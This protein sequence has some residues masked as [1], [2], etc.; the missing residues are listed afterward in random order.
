M[1]TA[2]R[3]QVIRSHRRRRGYSQTVLAGLVGRSESWL[4][5]VERGKLSVDSHEVLSRLAAVLRLPLEE[6]TGTAAEASPV[7]YTPTRA[8]ERAMMRYTSLR[9]SSRR[10]AANP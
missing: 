4:S 2:T 3:G 7:R 1:D 6:F 10:P 9:P 5:Q 8:I